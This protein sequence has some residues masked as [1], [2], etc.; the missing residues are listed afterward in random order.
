MTKC[1]V[2]DSTMAADE[3]CILQVFL[4]GHKQVVIK[5]DTDL[6]TTQELR[7]NEALV[8]SAVI[9]ELRIWIENNCFEMTLKLGAKNV[10]DSRFVAKWKKVKASSLSLKTPAAGTTT[11]TIDE[12]VRIVRMR[13]GTQRI[14]GLGRCKYYQLCGNR[15]TYNTEDCVKRSCL[16]P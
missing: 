15:I 7:D 12:L 13:M 14:Q 10:L 1:F 2:D 16:P 3:L 6:L 5:R 8:A 4:A 9:E 11:G